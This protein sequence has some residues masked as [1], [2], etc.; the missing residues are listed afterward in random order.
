LTTGRVVMHY[1]SGSMTR[2]SKALLKRSPGLFVEIS[3]GDAETA[4]IKN[5]EE[6]KVLTKRGEASA[7]ASVTDKVPPGIVFVPFHFEGANALTISALD[8]VAK[9][10]E[11]KVAACRIEKRS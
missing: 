11:Y 1:N 9:I 4:K 7:I 10:P 3:P 8:P 5:N 2:R 6:V